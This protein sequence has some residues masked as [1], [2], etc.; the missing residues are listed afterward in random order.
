MVDAPT[1][2]PIVARPTAMESPVFVE[3]RGTRTAFAT[4]GD[5]AD[6]IRRGDQ[7]RAEQRAATDRKLREFRWAIAPDLAKLQFALVDLIFGPFGAKVGLAL[8]VLAIPLAI[9]ALVPPR[10]IG[11]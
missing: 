1:P 3:Y 5:L 8:M 2:L 9:L 4:P 11:G 10:G 6:H 7:V